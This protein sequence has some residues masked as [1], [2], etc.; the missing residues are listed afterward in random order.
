MPVKKTA[1]KST[2]KSPTSKTAASKGS[3]KTEVKK[4]RGRPVGSKN[5]PKNSTPVK[6]VPKKSASKKTTKVQKPASKRGGVNREMDEVTGF[7][8]GTDSQYIAETLMEGGESRQEII[9]TL[10]EELDTETRNGTEKPVANLVSGIV[11][12]M[13]E[14][15]FTIESSYRL[16]PPV[17]GARG[18]RKGARK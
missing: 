10:R 3:G 1:K 2:R 5:K 15:G 11:N 9:E 12:K 4:K 8:T 14:R 13:L 18:K 16:V 17:K 7:A 6:S